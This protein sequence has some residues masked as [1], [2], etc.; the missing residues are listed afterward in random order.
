MAVGSACWIESS[1][2]QQLN[3][4]P[5]LKPRLRAQA[6]ATTR[7]VAFPR[8]ISPLNVDD[9][10]ARSYR[11]S[12]T[13]SPALNPAST[14][15]HSRS[16]AAR[17]ALVRQFPRRTH[18][19]RAFEEGRFA[20]Y[21]KSSS[22]LMTTQ[23]FRLAYSQISAS[24]A[25]SSLRSSTCL[26]S[27]PRAARKRASAAGS[28]WSTRTFTRLE[29]RSGRLGVPHIQWR[30]KYLLF[31]AR[32]GRQESRQNL[33]HSPATEECPSHECAGRECRDVPR[34]CLLPR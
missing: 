4:D 29:E 34:T 16:I 22:L 9:H 7:R 10:S 12:M 30:R 20:R 25:R 18:R 21:R 24:V 27:T 6:R 31:R 33:L 3:P 32:H 8:A 2:G 13:R 17:S 11:T 15:G 28:W 14:F 23:S 26:Q 1:N 5:W 19:N